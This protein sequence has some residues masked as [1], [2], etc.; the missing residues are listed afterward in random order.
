MRGVGPYLGSS[1]AFSSMRSR[2]GQGVCGCMAAN[3]HLG[4]SPTFQSSL[5][6]T[7]VSFLHRILGHP[8]SCPPKKKRPEE[9]LCWLLGSAGKP[10]RPATVRYQSQGERSK[11][12]KNPITGE[13][14]PSLG[15]A[16][17]GIALPTRGRRR[18]TSQKEAVRSDLGDLRA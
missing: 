3:Q 11:S 6:V 12:S 16:P 17:V 10:A 2:A 9:P 13:L 8:C 4:Q 15:T 14:G 1:I 7:S 5:R 18:I